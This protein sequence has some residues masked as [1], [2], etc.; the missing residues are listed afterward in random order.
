MLLKR[1]SLWDMAEQEDLWL[2]DSSRAHLPGDE[3]DATRCGLA[4]HKQ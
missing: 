3:F 1:E 4:G 2:V